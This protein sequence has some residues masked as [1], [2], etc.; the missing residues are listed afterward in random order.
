MKNNPKYSINYTVLTGSD[1]SHRFNLKA[2][3]REIILVSQGYKTKQGRN[4]G[5]E[6][7]M[8]NSQIESRFMKKT[9]KRGELYFI[10]KARNGKVIGTSEMYYSK[11][12]RDIGIASV[13]KHGND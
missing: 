2:R 3:N 9:S 7:V 13:M 12:S 10:L 8:A 6:S 1:G 5:I 4:N 11:A